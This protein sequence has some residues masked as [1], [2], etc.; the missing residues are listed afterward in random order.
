MKVYLFSFLLFFATSAWGQLDTSYLK[1]H[2]TGVYKYDGDNSGILVKRTKRKQIEYNKD[3]SKVLT[4]TIEWKSDDEYWLTFVKEKDFAGC[5][6]KGY[7][8][9]TKIIYAD[10]HKYICEW[11]SKECGQGQTTF[12]RVE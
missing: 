1:Y 10:K 7:I 6:K 2:K 3:K 4:L 9:K 5:L 12:I 8:I 11:D